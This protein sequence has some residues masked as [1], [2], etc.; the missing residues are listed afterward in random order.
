MK[1]IIALI[2]SFTILL[3]LC[4]CRN[5]AKDTTSDSS[6]VVVEEIILD[7][8]GNDDA[9]DSDSNSPT[10][11]TSSEG[12]KD[13]NH[14]YLSA[15]CEDPSTCEK[16][17]ATMGK[18][19]GH[20]YIGKGTDAKCARCNARKVPEHRH[21]YSAVTCENPAICSICGATSGRAIGHYGTDRN[22]ES[23]TL[24]INCNKYEVEPTGH[25]YSK[26]TCNSPERC[27]NCGKT[28]GKALG[29]YYE[30]S[31]RCLG[32]NTQKNHQLTA[33]YLGDSICEGV[34]D[35][36]KGDAWSARI[37]KLYNIKGTNVGKSGWYISDIGNAT[38]ITEFEQA[39][40]V[41]S[42][43]YIILQGG[44]NDVSN[45]L[46]SW[47][48]VSPV[49]TSKF[50]TKTIC[51]ALENLIHHTTQL[52]PNAKIGF[53]INFQII[54]LNKTN[55]NK[56]CSLAEEICK[57]WNIEYIY[58]DKQPGFTDKLVLETYLPDKVHP[59]AAG[60]DII[61]PYIGEWMKSF[62]PN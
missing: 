10:Q 50:D 3:T 9:S 8:G 44:V 30:N 1:K 34:G 29:H 41:S 36:T 52:A 21:D 17:G 18:P 59:N 35:K 54:S 57:K 15:T 40:D 5:D 11:T 62:A 23:K 45:G 25:Q 4:A 2:L 13:C 37:E 61:A 7:A 31:D 32:C 16:C 43:D 58:L 22:C 46:S 60:Y 48:E 47:G 33:L 6:G 24:C 20:T 55:W 28:R 19:L 14:K 56:F 27:K 38:I 49:G 53:I 12:D 26:A 51:G 42:Y 39:G